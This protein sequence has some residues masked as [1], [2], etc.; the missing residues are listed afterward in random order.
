MN[1][2]RSEQRRE[3]SG[4]QIK[5]VEV[6]HTGVTYRPGEGVFGPVLLTSVALF[7]TFDQLEATNH[8]FSGCK[9]VDGTE[10]AAQR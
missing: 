1:L 5:L 9:L 8:S 6:S 2:Y 10:A 4:V 3:D 7:F